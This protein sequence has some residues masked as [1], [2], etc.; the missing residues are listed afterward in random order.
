[1]PGSLPAWRRSPANLRRRPADF[2]R[3]VADRLAPAKVHAVVTVG[4]AATGGS[5]AK[6]D[7]NGQLGL[8]R[9]ALNGDADGEPS[10]PGAAHLHLDSRL[11]A[12]DGMALAALFGVDRLLGVDQL[13]GR[14]TL[15]ADGP[16]NGDIRVDGELAGSGLDAAV[17]GTLQL[18]GDAAPK[19]TLQM[20]ATAA[21]LRPLQQAMTGQAGDAV[22]VSARAAVAVS[23]TDLSLTQIAVAAGKSSANGHL[24][25]Q[26][27]SPVAIDGDVTADNV[28]GAR[29]VALLL[30]LPQQAPG[31]AGFGRASRSAL[32][33]LPP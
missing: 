19:A 1:M 31:L 24:A 7:L 23:G 2:C 22:P 25:R 32:A 11:D 28:D 18:H 10:Q 5:T 17:R 4:H 15:T 13:P 27:A 20:L 33:P 29:I 30:G 6:L 26:L 12:D 21:D 16:L 3:R 9:L 8:M 14:A